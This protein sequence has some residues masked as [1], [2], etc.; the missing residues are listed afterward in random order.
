[1]SGGFDAVVIGEPQRAFYGNQFGM[2]FPVF[3]HYGVGLWVPGVGGAIDPGSDAHDLVMA[4]AGR[5]MTSI[6]RGLTRDNIACPSAYDRDRNPHRHAEVWEDLGHPRHPRQSP[7]HRPTGLEPATHR[8]SPHRRRRRLPRPREQTP[9]E[10]PVPMGLVNQDRA[11]AAHPY[12]TVRAEASS[13]TSSP[14]RTS[15]RHCA[16]WSPPNIAASSRPTATAATKSDSGRPSP[17]ATRS[18]SSTA[19]P[20]MRVA[21]PPW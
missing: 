1:M 18:S 4:P 3:V 13:T 17:T 2:I 10:R 21:T 11:H 12:R 19:P 16:D 7:L 6:A 20:S 9:L 8:R 5:G 14:A 15:P